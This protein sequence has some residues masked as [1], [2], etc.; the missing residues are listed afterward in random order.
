V[1]LTYVR[2]W[3][4]MV[5]LYRSTWPFVCGWYVVEYQLEIFRS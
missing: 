3:P 4:T 5:R 1:V 2:D